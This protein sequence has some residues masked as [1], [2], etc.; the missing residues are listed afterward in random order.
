MERAI[1]HTQLLTE[2]L[3]MRPCA[4]AVISGVPDNWAP[5]CPARR[6]GADIFPGTGGI[7]VPS[8]P[9]Q[10][11]ISGSVR[12]FETTA[13]VLV[14]A[15]IRGLPDNRGECRGDIFGFHIHEGGSCSGT[16]ADP[17]ADTGPHYNPNNC[18]HP[19][20]AG[21]MPPL[22]GA[23][24]LA[25]SVFLTDRFNCREIIGRTVVVHVMPDD[26]STQPSGA[27]GSKI[28]CGIIEEI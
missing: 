4:E 23:N 15:E 24:G 26:L 20:H 19:W 27:S 7:P 18:L 12:F 5:C 1:H 10:T 13:G 17:F 8:V 28:A 9:A 16:P 6:P 14:Y 25:L 3:N 22:F 21:D 2:I 11:G